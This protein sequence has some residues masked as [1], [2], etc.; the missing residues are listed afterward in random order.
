MSKNGEFKMKAPFSPTG[1][2]P[3]AIDQLVQGVQDGLMHQVLLGA[4]GTG[5]SIAWNETVTVQ[6][7]DGKTVRG[8]IGALIDAQIGSDVASQCAESVEVAPA[9]PCRRAGLGRPKR[10]GAMEAHHGV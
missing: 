6:F 5:K 7:E 1:D 2:Q 8:A 4:T 3:G 10:R 9:V